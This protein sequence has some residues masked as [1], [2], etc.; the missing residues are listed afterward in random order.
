VGDAV[1]LSIRRKQDVVARVCLIRG[2]VVALPHGLSMHGPTPPI[3]LAYIAAVLRDAGHDLTVVDAA[4]E[5]ID[6]VVDLPSPIGAIRRT[7]LSAEEI[8]ARVPRDTQMVGVSIMFLHEWPQVRELLPLLRHRAPGA[9]IVLGGETATSFWPRMLQE[10]DEIDVVVLGE[11]EAT[12][13]ELADRIATGASVLG[14]PGIVTPSGD[15]APDD[16]GLPVRLRALDTVPRPAWEYFPLE[17]YWSNPYLGVDLGR[18]MPVMATRGCPYKC[19]FC[20]SPQ[21]WTTRYVVREPSDVV[22]EI[23]DHVRRRGVTNINFCDLT[24]ITKRQWT[25]RFCD[26]LE[27]RRLGITW[28]LPVGTRA[29]ALDAE[30]LGRLHATGCRNITYA[31]ES[32]SD[33]MLEVYDKRVDLEHILTSLR[34]AHEVGLRTHVNIIVGHPQERW[35]DVARSMHFLLRAVLAGC[36]DAA[37]ILFCPYPGSADFD[38]LLERGQL[39]VDEST[40]YIGLARASSAASSFNPRMPA[41]VQRVL[42]LAML[43]TFYGCAVLRRPTRLWGMVSARFTGVETT[44]FDQM[45]R[46]RRQAG[47]HRPDVGAGHGGRRRGG[48]GPHPAPPQTHDRDREA[49]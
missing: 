32:G 34:A 16:G 36:D 3:G 1:G 47:A 25:L 48:T 7:G 24:A 13:L 29:E 2:P 42:Q 49:V 26:E 18:S 20:S 10:C 43:A 5:G 28:Q 23:E 21:M 31:P 12:A 19:S 38:E 22:D 4:G 14:M 37:V 39:E 6:Q 33:R 8:V 41:R 30:V 15:H 35:S 40:C 45:M 44:Y 11:G 17:A 27:S 46:T 9:T